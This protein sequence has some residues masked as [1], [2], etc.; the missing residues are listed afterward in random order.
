M[1]RVKSVGRKFQG[2][3]VFMVLF[4]FGVTSVAYAEFNGSMVM[5]E[6]TNSHGKAMKSWQIPDLP[7]QASDKA[8]WALQ[9]RATLCGGPGDEVLAT[10][11]D[12]VVELDGDPVVS[13]DFAV[14]AGNFDT[15]FTITSATVGFAPISNPLAFASAGVTLTDG[16]PL[17]GDGAALNLIPP[18]T[19]LYQATYNSGTVFANLLPS[20]LSLP[21]AG[22]TDDSDDS[23]VQII[24]GSV[25]DIQ[26]SFSFKLSADDSA[27]GTS[28]F[29]VVIPEPSTSILIVFGFLGLLA[30]HR[31]R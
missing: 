2:I 14:N 7:P 17:P 22:T 23:G 1:N 8:Q 6:V 5:I 24:A 13:L 12:L 3:L 4:S 26:T 30:C 18:N 21:G 10:I 15:T 11:E 31:R 20:P 9:E 28:Q 19:G 27:S 16:D 25:T 29:E